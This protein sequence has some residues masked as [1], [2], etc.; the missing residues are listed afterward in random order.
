MRKRVLVVMGT[1]SSILA[2]P[3]PFWCRISLLLI[4]ITA[5][6]GKLIVFSFS[7]NESTFCDACETERDVSFT[8][9]RYKLGIG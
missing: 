8:A 2:Y 5:A 7:N 1:L 4:T 6:P 9:Y 3:Y